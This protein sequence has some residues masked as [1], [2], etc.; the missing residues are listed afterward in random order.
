MPSPHPLLLDLARGAP[1]RP[2]EAQRSLLDSAIEHRMS[3]LLQSRVLRGDLA[4]DAETCEALQSA[5]L[6]NRLQATR[7][8]RVLETLAATAAELGVELATFKGPTA[9]RWYDRPDERIYGDLDLLLNPAHL[10]RAAEIVSALVP[11]YRPPPDLQRLIDGR[12]LQSI[13]V[14]FDGVAIDFHLEL[15]KFGVPSRTRDLVWSETSAYPLAD[16]STVRVLNPEAA[17]VQLLVHLNVDRFR[18]LLGYVDVAR[19]LRRHPDLDWDLVFALLRAEGLEV[20]GALTLEAVAEVIPLDLPPHPR[21]SGWSATAWRQIW[22]E[23]T[24]LQGRSGRLHYRNRHRHR[25]LPLLAEGRRREGLT[26]WL[27]WLV[28][29]AHL[30]DHHF[31]DATGPYWKRNLESRLKRVVGRRLAN[32]RPLRGDPRDA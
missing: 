12:H 4:L 10:P 15:L 30:A 27:R 3:G 14:M 1:L 26:R 16:V 18:T 5:E 20:P 21:P 28:P 6:V 7:I 24:R 23:S 17:L 11:G 29:P 13:D 8:D 32:Q 25:L 9:A 19:L 31:P 22:R 2:P